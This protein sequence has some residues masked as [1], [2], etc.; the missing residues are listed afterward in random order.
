MY[1]R[2]RAG[3][4]GVLRRWSNRIL[5]LSPLS[6]PLVG[7]LL[8][9][10]LLLRSLG[11][12][13]TRMCNPVIN[14]IIGGGVTVVY[15]SVVGRALFTILYVFSL[16]L[17]FLIVTYLSGGMG[18]SVVNDNII[19]ISNRF[20]LFNSFKRFRIWELILNP[21]SLFITFYTLNY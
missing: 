7:L 5:L 1:L 10:L 12:V 18:S 8:S 15:L 13:F 11:P 19:Y 16:S 2:F 14:L 21:S 6:S 4:V 17:T 20:Y 3:I 9:S